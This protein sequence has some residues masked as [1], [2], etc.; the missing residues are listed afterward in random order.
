MSELIVRVTSLVRREVNTAV[1]LRTGD[2]GLDRLSK[3]V[4]RNGRQIDLTVTEHVLLE[5][6]MSNSG[7]VLSRK[8]ILDHVWDHS[9]AGATNIVDVC[10]R[11][12]RNKIGDGDEKLIR[13][14]RN[15]GYVLSAADEHV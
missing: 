14:G 7:R 2:L 4:R 1:V 9:F 13:T 11:H 3:E 12:L 8:M 5:Y 15:I 6:L 10:V